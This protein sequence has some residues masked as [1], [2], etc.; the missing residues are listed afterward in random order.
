MGHAGVVRANSDGVFEMSGGAKFSKSEAAAH[1]LTSMHTHIHTLSLSILP[2]LP[3]SLP[4]SLPLSL[5]RKISPQ[6]L[7]D[8]NKKTRPNES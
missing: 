8:D 5:S 4:L 2:S 1:E 7:A 6:N 3:P